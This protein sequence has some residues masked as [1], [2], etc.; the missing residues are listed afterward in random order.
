MGIDTIKRMHDIENVLE[1]MPGA[2]FTYEADGEQRFVFVSPSLFR[3][4]GFENKEAFIKSVGNSFLN[5]V[6]KEDLPRVLSEIDTQIKTGNEDF[7]E[8]R[9]A[10]ADGTLVWVLDR[11]HLEV[12][13]DD[14]KRYFYVVII[15]EDELM[16]M[17]IEA[18]VAAKKDSLT[19]LLNHRSAINEVNSRIQRNETGACAMV[20]L[21]NF[22]NIN[23]TYGHL[24]GDRVLVRLSGKLIA[25]F[26]DKAVIGRFGGDEFMF[27]FPDIHDAQA[28]FE[29]GKRILEAMNSIVVSEAFSLT[30]SV[31]IALSNE[32][33]TTCDDLIRDADDAMYHAKRSGKN[34]V[35]VATT[36]PHANQ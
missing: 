19:G 13:E 8:Y 33:T 4:L 36:G 34:K 20:D 12:D 2:V 28:A 25:L 15:E 26:S 29:Q 23:D 10:K 9:I 16:R 3:R 14:G 27:F 7:V 35:A 1:N 22:K 24:E 30:G 32:S 31:G 11:G 18:N 5:F 21:D 6:S 17:R